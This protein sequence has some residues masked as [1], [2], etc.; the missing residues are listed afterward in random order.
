M[1]LLY[2]LTFSALLF[3]IAISPLS[4]AAET[5]SSK[6][7]VQL[8]FDAG[9]TVF[10]KRLHEDLFGPIP[11]YE[12]AELGQALGIAMHKQTSVSASGLARSIGTKLEVQNVADH[13][14]TSVRAIDYQLQI[15]EEWTVNAFLG[16]GR[17]EFRSPAYGYLA[18]FGAYYRPAM[19]TNIGFAI[20][21]QYYDKLARDKIHPDDPP[22][23]GSASDSFFDIRVISATVNFYF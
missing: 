19:L 17:Y 2:K 7:K 13:M 1:A 18:G 3:V 8:R 20:E 5:F 16:A 14:L 22:I 10:S 11:S 15:N 21:G 12:S 4:S 6:G 23:I 9:F